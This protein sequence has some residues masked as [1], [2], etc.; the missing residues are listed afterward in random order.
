MTA[1]PF[2]Q[3]YGGSPLCAAPYRSR[4]EESFGYAS[5][6]NRLHRCSLGRGWRYDL[7][8]IWPKL[9][10]LVAGR[11]PQSFWSAGSDSTESC[12]EVREAAKGIHKHG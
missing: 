6:L 3:L 7:E 1:R 5:R 4:T 8:A 11:K 2:V 12:L 9:L 10:L